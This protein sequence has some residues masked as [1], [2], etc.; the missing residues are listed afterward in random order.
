MS[1]SHGLSNHLDN[2]DSAMTKTIMYQ[3]SSARGA[4]DMTRIIIKF[5]YSFG[6]LRTSFPVILLLL[7]LAEPLSRRK[8]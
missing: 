6:A 8:C 5:S 3:R 2:L 1:I 7:A 4:S